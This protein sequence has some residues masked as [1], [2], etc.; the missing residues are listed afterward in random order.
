MAFTINTR[1]SGGVAVLGL[2]GRLVLGNG[3]GQLREA[4][5]KAIGASQDLL[6]D[7]AGLEYMDSAGLGELV[8]AY[9]SA[10]ARGRRMKLLRPQPRIGSMLQ[11]TKLYSTFE[12]FEDET[13]ALASFAPE[14]ARA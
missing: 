2:A 4:V 11:I 7:L 5:Q 9:A 8:G 14:A 1:N 12:V 10:S 3:T 13:A 6:I